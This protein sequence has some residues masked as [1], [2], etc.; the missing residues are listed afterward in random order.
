MPVPSACQIVLRAAERRRLKKLAYSQTAPCQQVFR[1]RIVPGAAHGYSNAKIAHRRSVVAD[2]VRLWR[3]RYAREG[4]ADR[5]RSGRPATF[6]PVQVAEIKA[7]ACQLPTETGAP[8]SRWSCQDLAA[9]AVSRGITAAIGHGDAPDPGRRRHQALAIPVLAVPR[10][11]DFAAK[12]GRVLGL[13]SRVWDDKPFGDHEYVISS[14][15]KTPSR[16]AA[17]AASPSRRESPAPCAATATTAA[18]PWPTWPPTT[19]TRPA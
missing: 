1:V 16:P 14:D 4:L 6:T 8:L 13:Y 5:S 10:D 7:L 17:A 11:P 9:R 18:A 3:G 2:T 15:E 12:A 19:S